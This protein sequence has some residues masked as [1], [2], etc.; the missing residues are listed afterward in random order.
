MFQQYCLHE[1]VAVCE[2]NLST[3][4]LGI[5][6]RIFAFSMLTTE[7]N[8]QRKLKRCRAS[9]VK[10]KKYK[11][12]KMNTA[13]SRGKTLIFTDPVTAELNAE[14]FNICLRAEEMRK[15]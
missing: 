7:F 15:G 9:C 4:I 5:T 11:K 10:V 2:V 12:F 13:T 14:P 1:I 8:S 6:T 3:S